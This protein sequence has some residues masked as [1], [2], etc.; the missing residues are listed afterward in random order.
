MGSGRELGGACRRPSA[1]TPTTAVWWDSICSTSI[2]I[3]SYDRLVDI[4]GYR[5]WFSVPCR[6]RAIY[7]GSNTT[8]TRIASNPVCKMSPIVLSP[9]AR[10]PLIC[11][12]L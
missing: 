12:P 8:S 10:F 6:L 11:A 9:P 3:A 5:V 1:L 4:Y 2:F 7:F